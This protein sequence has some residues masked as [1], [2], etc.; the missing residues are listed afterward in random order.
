M[1]RGNGRVQDSDGD[2]EDSLEKGNFKWPAGEV[3][4][5]L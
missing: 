4:K 2:E 3:W 1:S 5:P